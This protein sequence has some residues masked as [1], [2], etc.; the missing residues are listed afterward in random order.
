MTTN[1]AQDSVGGVNFDHVVLWLIETGRGQVAVPAIEHAAAALLNQT[2]DESGFELDDLL[3]Q[4]R[5]DDNAEVAGWVEDAV[6][7]LVEH[8][9][10][11][12]AELAIGTGFMSGL[13]PDMTESPA[14]SVFWCTAPHAQVHRVTHHDPIQLRSASRGCG[15]LE[16]LHFR[17]A[18]AFEG[19]YPA[20]HAL[21]SQIACLIRSGER[22]LDIGCGDGLFLELV[23]ERGAHGSGV[24]LDPA[25]VRECRAKGLDVVEG[26][27]QDVEWSDDDTYDFISLLQII[28]H[29]TPDDALQL[30][31]AASRRLSPGGRLFI[32]TPNA[33]NPFVAQQNFWLDIT[34]VRLYP[35]PLLRA[36]ASQLGFPKVQSGTM[37]DEMDTWC[38]AFRRPEDALHG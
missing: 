37:G 10:P 25:K 9:R 24:E 34:H 31:H 35:A 36:I 22:V 11:I 16:E 17:V 38:Y 8:G 29:L 26:R 7:Y 19:S 12:T 28:E 23:G 13:T 6:A 1:D 21:Y 3:V 18:H 30:L 32:V 14:G 20:R 27:L 15:S 5:V 33:A 2:G 4:L